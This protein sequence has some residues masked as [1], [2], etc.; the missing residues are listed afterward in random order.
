MYRELY[1][2]T[3]G[4]LAKSNLLKKLKIEF[5]VTRSDPGDK[6]SDFVEFGSDRPTLIIPQHTPHALRIVNE[7]LLAG[8]AK[9]RPTNQVITQKH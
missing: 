3:L 9:R 1:K 6:F 5:T 2:V 4:E 8:L 7:T